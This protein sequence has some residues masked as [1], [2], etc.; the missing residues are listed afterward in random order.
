M[1]NIVI[2]NDFDYIQGGASKV[3]ID[4]VNELAKNKE[5]NVYFFSG[6]SSDSEILDKRIIKISTNTNEFLYDKNKIRGLILGLYNMK[7]QKEMKKL[8]KK[9][10]NKNTIIHIHG[11]T[12]CLSTSVIDICYKLN[13]KVI[14]TV[15]DY[16]T[17]CPNGGLF[18]FKKN[19]VCTKESMSVKCMLCNCDSRNYL[20]KIYRI[21]RQK[22]Y[23]H[24]FKKLKY[25]ITISNF[26]EKIL[27]NS[28]YNNIKYFRI[29][30]PVEFNK[31]NQSKTNYTNNDYYIY[32]GRVEQEKGTD[33]FCRAITDLDLKGI[34]VGEGKLKKELEKEYS[35]IEFVGWKN[36]DEV[37]QYLIKSRMLIFPSRL[38][39]TMGLTVLEALSNEIPCAI[40]SVSAA[41]EYIKYCPNYIK[42]FDSLS[43]L[44][45][46]IKK[47]KNETTKK[48][49]D[50]EFLNQ[51]SRNIYYRKLI[52][53]YKEVLDEKA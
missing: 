51:F 50:L 49:I 18:N 4:T 1:K 8:L 38:Y 23:I 41:N 25:A 2:V 3:A 45:S 21:I 16:F 42:K 52:K 48:D 27:K 30:N 24:T 22:I 44:K 43:E 37:N 7:A 36:S 46:I 10:D 31:T 34:V 14:L 11:W 13:F 32:V 29:N 35:N 47:N 15:H 26:S 39:E 12:K 53:T 5:L 40:S 20:F 17:I 33:I 9:L 28:F 6:T 19:R